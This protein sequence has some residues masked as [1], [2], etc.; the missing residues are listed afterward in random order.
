MLASLMQARKVAKFQTILINIKSEFFGL[1]T[2]HIADNNLHRLQISAVMCETVGQAN[3][4]Q[5]ISMSQVES[6]PT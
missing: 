1:T 3:F 4:L 2:K 5:T 6:S